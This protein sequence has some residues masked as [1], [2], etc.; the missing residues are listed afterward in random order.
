MPLAPSASPA[1]YKIPVE[2][3]HEARQKGALEGRNGDQSDARTALEGRLKAHGHRAGLCML[4]QA[5]A[6]TTR[7]GVAVRL[8]VWRQ[9]AR[10]RQS[11]G[12]PMEE[13]EEGGRQDRALELLQASVAESQARGPIPLSRVCLYVYLRP[14][15]AATW[16]SV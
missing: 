10:P 13:V 5:V 12:H 11:A 4:R 16:V 1:N 15:R 6:G 8:E 14:F 7:G 2:E 3:G 9:Q